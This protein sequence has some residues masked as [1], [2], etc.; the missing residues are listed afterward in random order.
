MDQCG[1]SGRTG[2]APAPVYPRRARAQRQAGARA[3]TAHRRPAAGVALRAPSVALPPTVRER[4]SLLTASGYLIPAGPPPPEAG[5]AAADADVDAGPPPPPEADSAAADAD[6]DARPPAPPEAGSA[7]ADADVDA[8]PP[9]PPE[10]GSAA[11]DA[12]VDA[13]PPPPPEA[14]SAAADADARPAR[15]EAATAAKIRILMGALPIFRR[16]YASK[17]A[18]IAPQPEHATNGADCRVPSQGGET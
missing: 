11:A 8:G 13:G 10:A 7:A 14:D 1:N 16:L 4:G 6:V 18:T 12:D 9:P 3:G 5:S 15:I 17:C 2:G